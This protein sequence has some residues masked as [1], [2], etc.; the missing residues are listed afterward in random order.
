MSGNIRAVRDF[1]RPR[2]VIYGLVGVALLAW[3]F[4]SG[5]ET[6]NFAPFVIWAC[7]GG[8]LI[9]WLDKLSDRKSNAR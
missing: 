6:E 7:G 4:A 2:N 8:L 3:A 9:D 1:R 5:L